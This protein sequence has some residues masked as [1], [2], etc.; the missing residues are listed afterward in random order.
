MDAD[1]ASWLSISL[2][3]LNDLSIRMLECLDPKSY[4]FIRVSTVATFD[5]DTELSTFKTRA[6]AIFNGFKNE[7]FAVFEKAITKTSDMKITLNVSS[8]AKVILCAR[9]F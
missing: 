3:R 8:L 9:G 2:H 6:W 5:Y 7:M 4:G 1:F